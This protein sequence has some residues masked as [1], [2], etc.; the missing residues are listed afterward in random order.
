MIRISRGLATVGLIF[1][2]FW[3]QGMPAQS[4]AQAKTSEEVRKILTAA[5][6]AMTGHPGVEVEFSSYGTGIFQKN[7]PRIRGRARVIFGSSSSPAKIRVEAVSSDPSKPQ[8]PAQKLVIV[9]DGVMMSVL[10]EAT[11]TIWRSARHRGGSLLFSKKSDIFLPSL[12]EPQGLLNLLENEARLEKPAN[13][14]GAECNVIYFPLPDGGG[15]IYRFGVEDSLPCS[16]ELRTVKD[17]SEGTRVLEID[18]CTPINPLSEDGF[19]LAVPPGFEE[20]EY[21]LGGPAVGVPA[22]PWKVE[23]DQKR[24]LSLA[25]MKGNVVVMDFWATWCGPCQASL[26]KMRALDEEFRGRPL[27]IVGLTWRES[28]DARAYFAEHGV[29]YATFAGDA[30]ADAYGVNR[31][32]I[33]TVFVIGP[34]GRV[35]DY[36][37]GYFGEETDC[38]L[39]ETVTRSLKST[40]KEITYSLCFE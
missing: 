16:F 30:L 27:R 13:V 6:E 5:I 40:T 17:G 4:S 33:P 23:D 37:I 1:S 31:A 38:L 3:R 2:C 32:G 7:T 10:E 20:K 34:D 35:V 8:E 12:L 28:G 24:T 18:A 19:K 39:R 21:T 15:Y 25:S 22:P 14:N 26:P 29:K 11:H 36:F 9:S